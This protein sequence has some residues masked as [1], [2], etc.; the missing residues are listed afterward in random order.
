MRAD[1]ILTA[2]SVTNPSG[3]YSLTTPQGEYLILEQM[4]KL[5]QGCTVAVF[6]TGHFMT[7]FSHGNTGQDRSG[8]TL[9]VTHD[10]K[11]G[12]PQETDCRRDADLDQLGASVTLG[13]ANG[14][15]SNTP[16]TRQICVSVSLSP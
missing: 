10:G 11:P 13:S 5:E 12:C 15:G 14:T 1:P 9:G 3:T 4:A 7:P 8:T 2:V 6:L 16:M